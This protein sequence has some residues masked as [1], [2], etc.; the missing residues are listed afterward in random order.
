[1]SN[2]APAKQVCKPKKLPFVIMCILSAI[3]AVLNVLLCVL[4]PKYYT[5]IN[6]FL[7]KGPD[8][9]EVAAFRQ[10]SADMTQKVESEGIVMLENKNQTLPLASGSKINLFG[11][12]SRDTV[13]GGSGS[14]SGDSSNNITLEQGLTN[15]GFSVNPEL[16]SFYNDHFVERVG[17][18]FTGNNF[19]INEPAVNEYSDEMIANAKAY[20]DVA[21]FVVSRL[22][23]EG[24]DLPMDMDPN[25]TTH[26]VASGKDIEQVVKGGDAGKHYLELQSVEQQVLDML[27]ENFG[28]VVVLVNSTNAME[29][30]FLEDEGV[31]A[32]LWIGCLGSTGA[33]A[34]GEVLSGA[35]N[36][37]GRTT[38]TFAYA[39]ESAPSYYSIGAYNYTN[40]EWVNTNPIGGGAAP[41]SYHYVDY[42]EG[43]Y[44]GYR[45]YETAAEDGFIDYDATVQYPFGYGLSYTDFEESISDFSFDGNNVTMTVN[46]KNNGS[47]AGKALLIP[48]NPAVGRARP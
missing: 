20:S 13:Y 10:A 41:D 44:V 15:A 12:G 8:A 35:V 32:A 18:G 27:K 29:L 6:S 9:D 24:A 28:T 25:A 5:T 46:V 23:G 40:C 45:Y 37:S 34:V 47:V 26:I 7:Y 4:V 33:N 31:D 22:G 36:P 43:I 42:I 21:V 16:V 39:V 17:V 19:D 1:M 14:G 2:T 48:K 3:V 11:Y 38:D 30:G